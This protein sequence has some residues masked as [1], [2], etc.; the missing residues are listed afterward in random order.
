MVPETEDQQA[1]ETCPPG[2]IARVAASARSQRQ[3]RRVQAWTLA[4]TVALLAVIGGWQFFRAADPVENAYGGIVCS[5]VREALPDF[6]DRQL[7]EAMAQ[8]V[9]RHLALCPAC[10]DAAA[11][12]GW[13]ASYTAPTSSIT[14]AGLGG[15]GPAITATVTTLY[16]SF[17]VSVHA[18][19]LAAHRLNQQFG[20]LIAPR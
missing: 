3:V 18:D 17:T 15:S 20:G 12:L 11:R 1:W 6:V 8:K 10:R 9:Q 2:E 7:D 14:G 16:A 4:S 13:V 19:S 5:D